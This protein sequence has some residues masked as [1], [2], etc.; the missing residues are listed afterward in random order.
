[1]NIER[2]QLN[3]GSREY[4]RGYSA[5][6]KRSSQRKSHSWRS[7]ID[8]LAF[9][10]VEISDQQPENTTPNAWLI[11]F[12]AALPDDVIE[13]KMRKLRNDY[14]QIDDAIVDKV[15]MEAI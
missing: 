2:I 15:I 9:D 10:R 1:M 6:K 3:T 7:P 11:A 8:A 14:E 5:E 4:E 13:R 12:A